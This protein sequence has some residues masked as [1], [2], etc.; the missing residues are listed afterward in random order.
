ME[1]ANCTCRSQST[2][3]LS[4]SHTWRATMPATQCQRNS[5]STG[6]PVPNA[7]SPFRSMG[8]PASYPELWCATSPSNRRS[9][10]PR[11]MRRWGCG[12]RGARHFHHTPTRCEA[13]GEVARRE[14]LEVGRTGQICVDRLEPPGGLQQKRRRIAA[15]ACEEREFCLHQ[16][17]PG[18]LKVVRRPRLLAADSRSRAAP[19]A[20]DL[21]VADAAA[22]ARSVRRAESRVSIVARSRNAAAAAR[23]PRAR[24]RPADRSNASATSSSGPGAASARCH[25]R[26]SG[27]RCGSVALPRAACTSRLSCGSAD[28]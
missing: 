6:M 15:P 11:S 27:S 23:P 17:D 24:A 16:V 7:W 2:C 22:S 25:A 8:R 10:S 3:Q 21:I 28:P 9:E 12:C 19:N 13:A 26:R 1:R 20:P 18:L 14:G 4:S 5:S